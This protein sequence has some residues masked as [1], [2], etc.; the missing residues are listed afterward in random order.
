MDLSRTVSGR[1]ERER[2]ALIQ[3]LDQSGQRTA[4]ICPEDNIALL[5]RDAASSAGLSWPDKVG[6][7][8]IMGTDFATKAG[9][10]CLRYDFRTMGRLAVEALATDEAVEHVLEPTL[11]VGETT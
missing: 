10:S 4:L 9:L 8:S 1:T 7:L 2:A 3:R 11:V 5:L 6:L